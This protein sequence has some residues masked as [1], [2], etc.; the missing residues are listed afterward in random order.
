MPLDREQDKK[1]QNATQVPLLRLQAL[2]SS[3]GGPFSLELA[4]GEC[5]AILGASG[6]GKSVL[7]RMVADLDPHAGKAYLGN[8]VRDAMPAPEWRRKLVY[9]AAE[10]A[11]WEP[12]AAAHFS[13]ADGP[14]VREMLGQLGL[15]T[16]LLDSDVTRLSTGQRQRLAL[17][18]SLVGRPQ[19]LLLDEP[20]AALDQSS[21]LAVEHLL[22]SRMEEGLAIIWVTH[23]EEQAGRVSTRRFEI[24]NKSLHPL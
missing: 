17:V 22:R 9:Q 16:V 24:R 3:H 14:L 13:D 21:I 4:A 6:S 8:Q 20:T 11:W 12:T 15:D 10:P 1:P 2:Q 19:V 18:R 5:V 7:L 23:S